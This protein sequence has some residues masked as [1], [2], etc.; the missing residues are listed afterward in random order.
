MISQIYPSELQRNKA[1]T[2]YTKA[3]FEDFYFS[4]SNDISSTSIYDKSNNFDSTIVNFQ[5]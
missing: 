3:T 1:Y 2:S 4:I 5:L